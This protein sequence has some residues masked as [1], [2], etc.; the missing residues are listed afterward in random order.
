MEIV[1]AGCEDCMP[2]FTD[3]LRTHK[4]VKYNKAPRNTLY[5]CSISDSFSNGHFASVTPSETIQNK[6]RLYWILYG[7]D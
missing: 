4:L 3:E 2:S 6:M 7:D 5:Y 1:N